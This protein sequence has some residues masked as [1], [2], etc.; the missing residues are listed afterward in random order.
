MAEL[1]HPPIRVLVADDDPLVRAGL[2]LL[3]DGDDLEV[4]GEATDGA[5][6]IR[7]V[8]AL[9]PDVVLMDLRMP[10]VDGLTATEAIRQLDDPPEVIALTTFDADENVVRALRAGAAGFLLKD[11]APTDII[12]AIH[13]VAAGDAQ[14]SPSVTR[15]L[16]ATIAVHPPRAVEARRRLAILTERERDIA[17]AIGEGLT[18]AEIARQLHLAVPT[19]KAHVTA[20]LAKLEVT[21]RVLVALLVHDARH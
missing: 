19:V 9:E 14:L 7:Q 8:G 10:N 12:A 21:N 17:D 1:N 11:T 15:R 4:V 5:E 6:A 20:I 13:H 3:L 2:R 18:N 16:L